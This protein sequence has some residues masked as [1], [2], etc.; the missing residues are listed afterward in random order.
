MFEIASD[1]VT[2]GK[3]VELE[4]KVEHEKDVTEALLI[5]EQIQIK[6]KCKKVELVVETTGWVEV[7]DDKWTELKQ[8]IGE[9]KDVSVHE[10]E[11][12]VAEA[13]STKNVELSK[14]ADLEND[15]TKAVFVVTE[16]KD[17]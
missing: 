6:E 12:S 9:K 10:T 7:S 17:V 4:E 1:I 8:E 11:I 15:V 13:T 16:E 14:E 3:E 5:L 2:S